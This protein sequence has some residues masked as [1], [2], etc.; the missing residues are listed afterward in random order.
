M[1]DYCSGSPSGGVP[2]VAIKLKDGRICDREEQRDG[3]LVAWPCR[4]V[5]QF[6][7]E[8]IVKSEICQS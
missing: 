8:G 7:K 4:G 2:S 3:D 1:A 6:G 5:L